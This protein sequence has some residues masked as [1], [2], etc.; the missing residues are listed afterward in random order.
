MIGINTGVNYGDADP[1]PVEFAASTTTWWSL[2][3]YCGGAGCGHY[4][5]GTVATRRHVVIE[6]CEADFVNVGKPAD[7]FSR[8]LDYGT[9]QIPETPGDRGARSTEYRFQALAGRYF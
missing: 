1:A 2:V 4:M 5:A 9:T 6:A 8:R 3:L 7:C